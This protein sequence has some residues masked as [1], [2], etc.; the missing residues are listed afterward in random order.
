MRNPSEHDGEPPPESPDD[1]PTG[2]DWPQ[3]ADSNDGPRATGGLEGFTAD[4]G[5]VYRR[6]GAY[7][8][9]SLLVAI[10]SMGVGVST[11]AVDLGSDLNTLSIDP[12]FGLWALVF[13]MLYRWSAQSAFGFTLGKLALGL[14]IVGAS[15]GPAG[16]LRILVREFSLSAMLGAA[17]FTGWGLVPLM[18]QVLLVYVLMRRPDQRSLHDLTVHTRV[19]RV[20]AAS[21][22]DTPLRPA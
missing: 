2:R 19:V 9:D 4:S 8:I 16:P 7:V 3:P 14:R 6:V 1:P 17:Q 5:L 11:G 22:S 12:S 10:V 15:G 20:A 18:V 13:E 21:D